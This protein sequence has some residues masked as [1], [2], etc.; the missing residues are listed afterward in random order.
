MKKNAPLILIHVIAWV[1]FLALPTIFK[2][3]HEGEDILEDFYSIPRLMNAALLVAVFYFNYYY[4]IPKLYMQGRYTAVALAGLGALV[5]LVLLNGSHLPGM[6]WRP[7]H[8]PFGMDHHDRG[9]FGRGGGGPQGSMVRV[10]GPPHNL[11][12]FMIVCIV[13][14][15]LRLYAQWKE[16]MEE[17]LHSEINFLKA[18]INPHFLFNT[19]N[20]IYSLSLTKSDTTPEA[21]LKLSEIMRYTTSDAHQELVPLEKEIAYISSYVDLQKLRLPPRIRVNYSLE[22]R[23]M[24]KRISPFVLI[25][26]VENAFKYGVNP[27]EDSQIDIGLKVTATHLALMVENTQ[28]YINPDM[29]ESTGVGLA[30]TQR[31]LDLLYS[32]RYKLTIQDGEATY[33]IE[34]EIE[35]A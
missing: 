21:V 1:L 25:P 3:T 18:Q 13:S 33:R 31:R 28:V 16:T 12:M 22:G 17:K 8:R 30:N 15:T 23:L 14:F 35:L 34:L 27:S 7:P 10:L 4:A 11:F 26:F 5:L 2:P 19:L 20:S 29:M 6:D 24:G 32:G 9:P